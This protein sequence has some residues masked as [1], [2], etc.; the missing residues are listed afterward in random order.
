M[1]APLPEGVR[2]GMLGGGGFPSPSEAERLETLASGAGVRIEKIL[3]SGHVTPPGEWY[4]QSDDEWVLLVEG[5]A[6]IGF[7]SGMQ[8]TLRG[9]E[10]VFLPAHVRHRVESTSVSPGCV[11]LAVHLTPGDRS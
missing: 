2:K 1:M 6:T 4:D 11:W 7:E 8:C 3:S 10:W 9:G 5:E